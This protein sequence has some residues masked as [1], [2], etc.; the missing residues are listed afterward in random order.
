MTART[1]AAV[2]RSAVRLG[3][4]RPAPLLPRPVRRGAGG[5]AEQAELTHHRRLQRY[6]GMADPTAFL[7]TVPCR[8]TG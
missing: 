6:R 2:S 5:D 7:R 4:A 8:L 1:P 3:A